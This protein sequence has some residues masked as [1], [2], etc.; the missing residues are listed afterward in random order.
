MQ[1]VDRVR[2]GIRQALRVCLKVQAGEKVLLI[3]DRER[4]GMAE[5]L[6]SELAEID[7]NVIDC[8][9][10]EDLGTRSED[11]SA[12][13]AFPDELALTLAAADVSIFL[14]ESYR[15]EGESF[16][17]PMLA[18]V[19]KVSTLR[20][21]HMPGVTEQVMAD[22]MGVD[23]LEVQSVSGRV[24]EMAKV[25]KKVRVRSKIGSDFEMICG[26]RWLNSNGVITPKRWMNLPAGEVF[27]SP[28]DLNG[29]IV[30][31]GVLGDH[32]AK[33]FG[34]MQDYPLFLEVENA[35]VT[36][37]ECSNDR[38]R[39]AFLEYI[40]VD[41]NASRVGEFAIGTNIGLTAL[42]GILLQDEKFPGVHV[43]F[44]H[45]YPEATGSGVYS[46]VHADG[47]LLQPDVW[48]D[49]TQLMEQGQFLF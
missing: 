7:A 8:V 24:F 44:G 25:A 35:H 4:I 43:A 31:D 6:K 13:L 32:F 47:V 40:S 28:V 9:V 42:S 26:H 30:V 2:D 10:M 39:A 33:E 17:R 21:A 20:H 41:E 14:A 11:G 38:L 22:A 15:G 5:I 3:C 1:L 19:N 27:T 29:S 23:Y 34:L 46:K 45:G 12:P 49:E 36:K 37:V 48:I 18:V 16:R